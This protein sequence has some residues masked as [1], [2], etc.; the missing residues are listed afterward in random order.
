MIEYV[1]TPNVKLLAEFPSVIY[2]AVCDIVS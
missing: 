1:C 2:Y